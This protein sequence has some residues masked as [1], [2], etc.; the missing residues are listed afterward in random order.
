MFR[1]LLLALLVTSVAQA[2]NWPNWRGPANDGHAFE[3]DPPITWSESEN[4]KWKTAIP[5]EGNSTPVIWGN[6]VFITTAIMQG[7]PPAPEEPA[8]DSREGRRR[9]SGGGN[10][11]T[12]GAPANPYNFDVIALDADSGKVLWQ[13][14]AAT[15]KPHEGRHPSTTYSPQSAIT[16]GTHVWVSFGSFGVHCYTVSGEH[17]WSQ[18]TGQLKISNQFGEGASAALAGDNL[19]VVLDQ[20][21]ASKIVAYNKITGAVVWEDARDEQ[22][23]WATPFVADID[24]TLQ[25]ITSGTL[26]IRSYNAADGSLLWESPGLQD[27]VIPMPVIG[28]GNVYLSSG[29]QKPTMRAIKLG[30]GVLGEEAYAWQVD[31]NTPYVSSPLLWDD[32]IYATR[33]LSGQLSAFNAVTG[34]VLYE[35]QQLGEIKQIYA[36]PAAVQD[37]IYIPGRKGNVVVVKKGPQFEILAQNVLEDGFDGSPA[38]VGDRIYLRGGANLYCIAK[39]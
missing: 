12:T 19:V 22:T 27:A 30:S 33:G 26:G 10:T 14:T 24:G 31:K 38:I 17:V 29:Y 34:E 11:M 25:V 4:I 3:G 8:D 6:Q 36:S 39:D 5:G 37:R 23:T 18:E 28:H 2:D 13:K 16:D 15:A 35:R 1:S 9:R 32:I 7:E 21:E 20:E